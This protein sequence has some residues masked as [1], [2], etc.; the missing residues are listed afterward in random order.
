VGVTHRKLLDDT[1]RVAAGH[2]RNIELCMSSFAGQLQC[3]NLI[4]TKG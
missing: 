4:R 1:P 3:V 2:C